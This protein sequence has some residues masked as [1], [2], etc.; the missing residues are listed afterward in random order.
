M[1]RVTRHCLWPAVA[2]AS[3]VLVWAGAAQYIN[4][5]WAHRN[6]YAALYIEK[7]KASDPRLDSWVLV[8]EHTNHG[9]QLVDPAF[10]RVPTGYYNTNSGVGLTLLNYPRRHDAASIPQ[11][12]RVGVIG[13]GAGTIATYGLP[14]DLFRFYEIDPEI[15]RVASGQ[16]GYFSFLSDSRARIEVVEGDGRISLERELANGQLQNYDVLIVDAFNGDAVP[17]HLL[18]RE[19]FELYLKSLRDEE[20]VIAVHVSNRSVELSSVVAAEAA[21]FHLQTAFIN[22]SGF[23]S[24]AV[25]RINRAS[26][27]ILLSRSRNVLSLPAIAQA[28]SPMH[29]KHGLHLW[30][31]EQSN[32]LQ[33]LR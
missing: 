24:S 22:D 14:G 11:G 27:W 17:V 21:C 28:S 15:V 32:L 5:S 9:I 23:S 3:L 16:Y 12:L 2:S 29:P 30:T 7:R 1:P 31:D 6:F 10:H 8:N 13:L 25:P 26:Q 19:A 18:T 4:S 20:S 33:I